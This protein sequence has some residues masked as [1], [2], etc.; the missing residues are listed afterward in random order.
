[1][2]D[3]GRPIGAERAPCLV[4][5]RLFA[6][7]GPGP[8]R[9]RRGL[10]PRGPTSRVG[11][12]LRRPDPKGGLP[13]LPGAGQGRVPADGEEALQPLLARREPEGALPALGLL[14]QPTP[15]SPGHE[16]PGPQGRGALPAPSAQSGADSAQLGH[17]RLW[18]GQGK[19]SFLAARWL[20]LPAGQP[21]NSSS[22]LAR[23][24][25]TSLLP[26]QGHDHNELLGTPQ[27][28]YL[29]KGVGLYGFM[30]S[31]CW[32]LTRLL[33]IKTSIVLVTQKFYNRRHQVAL[34]GQEPFHPLLWIHSGQYCLWGGGLRRGGND[35]SG[36]RRSQRLGID[37]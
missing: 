21:R 7:A 18:W 33:L 28:Q 20:H 6:R 36:R 9:R 10:T 30:L 37:P 2:P 16:H 24:G 34:V 23:R 29:I 12:L 3:K 31:V 27:C 1:M 4:W 35:C 22:S 26:L 15:P 5:A 14:L 11:P 13:A 19:S 25:M 17:L 32:H 8:R